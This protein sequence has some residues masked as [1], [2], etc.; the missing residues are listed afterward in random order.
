MTLFYPPLVVFAGT[1]SPNG[2]QW[3]GDKQLLKHIGCVCDNKIIHT[4]ASASFWPRP[5]SSSIAQVW[6][7]KRVSW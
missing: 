4:E 5:M 6:L 7:G 1:P 3:L 2:V